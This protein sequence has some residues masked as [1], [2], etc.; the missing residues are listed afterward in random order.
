MTSHDFEANNHAYLAAALA[1]LRAALDIGDVDVDAD[2]RDA[3]VPSPGAARDV[4]QRESSRAR[5][6][7]AALDRAARAEPPPAMVTLAAQFDLSAFETHV[8]LLAI[9]P[10]IDPQIPALIARAH[11]DPAK[12]APTFALAMSLCGDS[13]WDALAPAAPLRAWRLV[14]IHQSG[15]MPLI[16]APLRIDER[17]AAF[18]KGLNYLDERIAAMCTRLTAPAR[19]PPSQQRL[20][21]ALA[22]WLK[23]PAD[24]VV[25]LAGADSEC[26]RDVAACAAMQAGMNLLALDAADLP[27]APDEA[28]LLARLWSRETRL[29]PIALYVQG[30]DPDEPDARE[31]GEVSAARAPFAL[32]A[33]RRVGG[34]RL[35]ECREPLSGF[36]D[37]TLLR[38]AAPLP[39]ERAALWSDALRSPT[40]HDVERLAAEF[41]LSASGIAALAS[42]VSLDVNGD[43][44][45]PPA[46][47][48]WRVAVAHAAGALG[49]LAQ[50]IE[51]VASLADVKLPQHEAAQLARL[52]AHARERATVLSRYG[53]R[54]H[55]H[56]GLGLTALFHG[57]SGVGKTMAAEA[58]AHELALALFRIDLSAVF[59]K[60]IGQTA[61]NLRHVFDAAEAGGAVLFI[62]EADAVIGRR[63]EIKDSH[64]RYANIDVN[65]LLTRMESFGGVAIL[66]TNMKHALD[67]A[68]V[69]RLRFIVGFPYPGVEQRK[70]I[71][72]SVFPDAGQANPL[73]ID[74]LARFALTGGSI[75]NAALA[76]AHD[77]AHDGS[78]VEMHHVLDAIRWELRKIERPLSD[79]SFD[80][81]GQAAAVERGDE[82]APPTN[83]HAKRHA[84]KERTS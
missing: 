48:A 39:H 53:F 55:G 73:D 82:R 17:I 37:T 47:R 28:D 72:E 29:L 26:K 56:R 50:Q 1:W 46:R 14:E 77:A 3:R 5:E 6:L 51:P 80:W 42:E 83:E 2:G 41:A 63:T 30:A 45:A 66:A 35:I 4:Q 9:A 76:A 16:A 79:K 61:K 69:R 40:D 43:S 68:F 32:K 75:F 19:L 12:R 24:G 7:R 70:A 21:E 71:W 84:K 36:A 34:K 27:R 25:Q 33:L 8:M 11:G 54:R 65:Y 58:V 67:Q 44:G 64:D 22:K 15:S 38:I 62:D 20:A 49:G 52:V 10:E 78:K 60:Y 23:S 59:S 57:E 81:R 31:D 74:W 18:I 13:A